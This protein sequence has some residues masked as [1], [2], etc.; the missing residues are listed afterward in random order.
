MACLLGIDVGSSSIKTGL[1][2]SDGSALAQA[3]RN[4]V[5]FE[6]QPGFKE[7]DPEAWWSAARD[8]IREVAQSV[9]RSDIAALGTSGHISSL[10]F[11]DVSGRV[12]RPAIGF[13]DL[14][15]IEELND[16]YARFTREE[17]SERMGIDL[18]PAATWP[19]PKLLWLQKHEPATLE[20]A[21]R[22]L[23]AKDYINYRL[24]GEFASDASSFRGLV[25]FATGCAA[26][27]VLE[28][29]GLPVRLVPRLALPHEII[30]RVTASASVETGLP[31]GLPVVAGWNDLNACVLGSGAIDPG[32]S[33]NVTGTSEHLGSVTSQLHK[34]PE[35]ICAPYLAG[36]KLFYGVTSSGGG[37]LAW[38]ERTLGVNAETLL[39]QA[40]SVEP[41]ASGL[42]YLPYLEG[43]RSPIW[44]PKVAGAFVGLRTS[45]GAS[46]L[47]RAVLEGVAFSLRQI[48]ELV[49]RH[50]PSVAE[51]CIVSGGA[52]RARLWNQIKAD[53]LG[54]RVAATENPHAGILG[55]SILAAVGAGLYKNCEEAAR[56]M[57]RRGDEFQPC[58]DR[59]SRYAEL[60]A[61]Y[62]QLY[63]ALKNSFA[64]L[65]AT[66]RG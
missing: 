37:S 19:L 28:A 65:H 8:S 25:N 53:V 42:I 51:P 58:A 26:S 29:L 27:D 5:T 33:F 63:P 60:Y 14:R 59:S 22:V 64:Q 46:H 38:L 15:A 4:S 13:Q 52:A 30:G 45:H 18:P 12:L 3:T 62:G 39:E 40:A 41:G 57:V 43:E 24:T 56:A 9:P 50:A 31:E 2:A 20:L 36:K 44:D 55:A 10:T 66:R 17:L 11:V 21:H 6:P 61:V 1:I 32:D 23:Q 48:S 49:R 7:Q 35:L 16:L 34:V 54:L 47:A